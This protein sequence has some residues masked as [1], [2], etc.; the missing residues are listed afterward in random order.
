MASHLSA[1]TIRTPK[2]KRSRD[3]KDPRTYARVDQRICG[4][5]RWST[6]LDVKDVRTIE[7]VCS[8]PVEGGA[9]VQT[10]VR[11]HAKKSGLLILSCFWQPAS[12]VLKKLAGR[13]AG[14]RNRKTRGAT[15]KTFAAE[16]WRSSPPTIEGVFAAG[17]CRRGQSLVVWAINEGRGAAR[18]VDLYLMGTSELH[19][20]G[21][22]FPNKSPSAPAGCERDR[23]GRVGTAHLELKPTTAR[24][25]RWAVPTL[26]SAYRPKT[27]HR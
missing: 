4:W 22:N 15:G 2:S 19:A 6:C 14:P 13:N 1:S 3:G 9:T 21:V 25:A 24:M 16:A 8:R 12:L 5:R 23:R 11:R 7:V 20:P 26:L 27:R 17:D 10:E 18:A